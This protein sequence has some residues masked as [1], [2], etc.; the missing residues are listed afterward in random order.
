MKSVAYAMFIL[1]LGLM[2]Q[3]ERHLKLGVTTPAYYSWITNIVGDAP[4]DV[5]PILGPESDLHSY[6]PKPEDIKR[7]AGLDFLVVNGL[8]H[9]AFINP[10]IEACGN[11]NLKLINPNRGLP[12]IP[13]QRGKSHSHGE[14]SRTE[15]KEEKNV[16]Y[17]P[18]TWLSLTGAVQQIYTLERELS[19]IMPKYRDNFRKNALAYTRKIRQM[20]ADASFRLSKAKITRVATVHDGYSYFLQ[21]FGVDVVAILEPAHG[22]EPSVIELRK[23]IEEIKKTGAR[24]IFSELDFPK[25]YV[26]VIEKETNVRV[27]TFDHMRSGEY[28]KDR[29]EK[30]MQ[31][32]VD[33]LVRALMTEVK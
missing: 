18:H 14:A 26:D 19:Q 5:L 13:Y 29:F 30:A 23:T 27:Y 2:A 12:L 3:Q 21:E 31:S 17:N 4:V 9:D 28:K 32:N 10:M 8:G 33:T 1:A 20:K 11:R 7:L 22:I 16:S 24:V 15:S 25:K 6:Q